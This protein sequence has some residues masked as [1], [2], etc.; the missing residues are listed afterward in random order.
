MVVSPFLLVKKIVFFNGN[1]EVTSATKLLLE[2]LDSGSF[3]LQA[4]S[5]CF[6]DLDGPFVFISLFRLRDMES[7]H[8]HLRFLGVLSLLGKSVVE[9]DVTGLNLDISDT[10]SVGITH[11]DQISVVLFGE[12][13]K[14]ILV[15]LV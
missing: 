8:D 10:F 6:G 12:G 13:L 5:D 2:L 9:K 11:L 4:L 1:V 7:V 15:L 3:L 14:F